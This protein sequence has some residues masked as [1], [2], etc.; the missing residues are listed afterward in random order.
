MYFRDGIFPGQLAW[1]RILKSNVKNS[2]VANWHT[3]ISAPEFSRF[4]SIHTDFQPNI[5]WLYSKEKRKLLAPCTSVI[6]MI[7]NLNNTL[8]DGNICPCCNLM[9]ENIIDHCIH[10]CLYLNRE[11]AVFWNELSKLDL[12]V[13]MFL[14][15]QEPVFLSN[16]F[17]GQENLELS[18][19]LQEKGEIFRRICIFNLHFMWYKY[20]H[21]R[22]PLLSR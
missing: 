9:Y 17:L 22:V 8:F 1:K 15:I 14:N 19:V 13:Y 20:K 18:R 5:F 7:S 16:I 21:K 3:R 12:N 6:Q 2:A 11:R 4:K 10:E